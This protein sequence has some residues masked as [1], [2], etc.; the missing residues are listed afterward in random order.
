MLCVSDFTRAKEG[1]AAVEFALIAPLFFLLLLTLVAFA[2][3]LTA[4]HS[5]QHLKDFGSHD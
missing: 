5:L 3:Y 2:I 4:A 1:T